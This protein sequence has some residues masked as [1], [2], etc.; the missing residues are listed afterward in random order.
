L[1]IYGAF[2]YRCKD[3]RLSEDD[4]RV[5]LQIPQ[6]YIG[7]EYNFTQPIDLGGTF[8]HEEAIKSPL[9]MCDITASTTLGYDQV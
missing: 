8:A 3:G 9:R 1:I 5:T 4:M 2:S 6:T 7:S